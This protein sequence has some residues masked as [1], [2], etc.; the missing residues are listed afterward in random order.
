MLAFI[1]SSA[2]PV[3]PVRAQWESWLGSWMI[4]AFGACGAAGCHRGPNLCAVVLSAD[5]P[6]YCY[7]G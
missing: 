4:Y 2:I 6:A 1:A 5:D 7:E 3:Y